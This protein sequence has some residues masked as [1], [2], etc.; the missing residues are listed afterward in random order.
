MTGRGRPGASGPLDGASR[1]SVYL[2]VRRNFLD[3]FMQAFDAPV[4]ST[5]VG[6]RNRSN[7]PA[8]ALAMLNDPLVHEL[9]RRFAAHVLSENA[10]AADAIDSACVAAYGRRA[11]D[12]DQADIVAFLEQEQAAGR[13]YDDAWISLCHVL[14][15]A[16]ELT[17]LR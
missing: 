12:A 7:V 11:T 4:P 8:Q 9:A 2:E 3:P 13:S 6:C 14:F 5:T 10:S 1:R 17:H 16:K 15:N